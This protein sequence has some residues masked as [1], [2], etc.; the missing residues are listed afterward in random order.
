MFIFFPRIRLITT[1]LTPRISNSLKWDSSLSSHLHRYG[2]TTSQENHIQIQSKKRER[3]SSEGPN[4]LQ[5]RIYLCGWLTVKSAIKS[6]KDEFPL[7][8][9]ACLITLVQLSPK[10]QSP[11]NKIEAEKWTTN[12]HLL[13]Q[14]PG[15]CHAIVQT[16][17]ARFYVCRVNKM[18]NKIFYT[19]S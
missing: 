19:L 2:L 18:E 10:R 3:A 6:T 9:L 8:R 13:L 1:L 16:H 15:I 5:H 4:S 12:C 17:V 11:E 14:G 7:K